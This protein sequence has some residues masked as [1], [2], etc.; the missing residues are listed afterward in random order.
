MGPTGS[1]KSA[2]AEVLSEQLGA[3]LINGDAF[4][5]YRGFDIGTNK[6]E[7]RHRYRLLDIKDPAEGYGVGQF[8]LDAIE[9]LDGAFKAGSTVVIV[10]G[11]GLYIRALF[12][13]YKNLFPPP[14]PA[15]RK[16]LNEL[17]SEEVLD[18]LAKLEI[19]LEGDMLNPARAKRALERLSDN[20]PPLEF[21]LP[22]FQ[23]L[24]IGLD[25][26]PAVLAEILDVRTEEMMAK[27]WVDEVRHLLERGVPVN[28][29]AFRAIG[30]AE[31]SRF[32]NREFDFEQLAEQ[33]RVQTRQYAKR[34][35][36][37]LRSE[38]ALVRIIHDPRSIHPSTVTQQVLDSL[39]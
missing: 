27:G 24:K 32:L 37:W 26:D 34:Q 28:S 20:R 7:N 15:F 6:P 16:E 22:P 10:G 18:K 36:S 35:R 30:Y 17:S 12:E 13:E 11:T 23:K 39:I 21:Q 8:I 19:P 1:G 25:P 4:Q 14:S 38:P 31:I 33:I 5:V 9:I 29:P 3:I 2:V